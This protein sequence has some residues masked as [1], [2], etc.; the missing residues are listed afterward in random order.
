[1]RHTLTE[2]SEN[3]ANQKKPASQSAL[4]AHHTAGGSAEEDVV[5]D[6]PMDA[7]RPIIDEEIM[8]MLVLKM[9]GLLCL[10]QLLLVEL[11]NIALAMLEK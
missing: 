9:Q 2:C 6:V 5:F 4:Y 10:G 1:M 7:V 8:M 11:T 3:P